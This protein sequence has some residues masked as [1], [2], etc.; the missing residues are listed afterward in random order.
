MKKAGGVVERWL[1]RRGAPGGHQSAVC[2]KKRIF[3]Y[4]KRLCVPSV[5][6]GASMKKQVTPKRASIGR[7]SARVE[8]PGRA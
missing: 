3:F 4:F 6:T 8:R 1:G 2:D 5:F 7:T